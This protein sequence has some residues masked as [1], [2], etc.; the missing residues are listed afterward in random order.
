MSSEEF[1]STASGATQGALQGS[2]IG[3]P[4]GAIIGGIAGGIFGL[5]GGHKRHKQR[6]RAKKHYNEATTEYRQML[7]DR[8]NDY[9]NI[10]GNPLE[11]VA[12][13][14]NNLSSDARS[15]QHIQALNMARQ[16]RLEGLQEQLEASGIEDTGY[17]IAAQNNINVQF[18]TKL[19][20]SKFQD[21]ADVAKEQLGYAK[22]A[23]ATKNAA[24]DK[25]D[26]EK[27]KNIASLAQQAGIAAQ[28]ESKS[29]NEA[30]QGLIGSISKIADRKKTPDLS[31]AADNLN[32]N[33]FSNYA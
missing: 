10:F 33:D 19:I 23:E 8:Y 17:S 6:K 24:R 28:N 25:I 29:T 22:F 27:E 16:K 31:Q 14:Y 30:L 9:S 11:K 4:V 13:Y 5:V 7:Q 1:T 26:Q 18:D 12:N 32:P 2:A 20:E 15:A 21:Q 3:G